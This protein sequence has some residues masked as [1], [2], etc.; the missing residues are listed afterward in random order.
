MG[1]DCKLLIDGK[2]IYLDRGYVFIDGDEGFDYGKEYS[3]EKALGKIN[4][5]LKEMLEPDS[6]VEIEDRWY[7]N[8]WLKFAE[9][10][11]KNAQSKIILIPDFDDRYFETP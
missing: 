2:S 8:K 6:L 9:N 1:T 3:K 7:H 10:E 11:I 4:Y 5:L